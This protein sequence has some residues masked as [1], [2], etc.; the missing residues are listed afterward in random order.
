MPSIEFGVGL[1]IGEVI[2]GN[3]GA[4]DRLDF[5]VMGPA[6]NRT[7]RLESLTK[8]LDSSVLFSREFAQTIE[9]PVRHLGDHAMKGIDGQ[10][11][12]YALQDE[13]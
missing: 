2:Y 1:N 11:P 12:V 8:T 4:S 13:S 5:T 10:H 9:Q 7:A 6:V 3:V